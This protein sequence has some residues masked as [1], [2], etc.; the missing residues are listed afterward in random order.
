[1]VLACSVADLLAKMYLMKENGILT[2]ISNLLTIDLCMFSI[3]VGNGL[4]E[5][6]HLLCL[7]SVYC[8]LILDVIAFLKT[9][10]TFQPF[11]ITSIIEFFISFTFRTIAIILL[12]IVW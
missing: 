2:Y 6:A 5:I 7:V 9:E 4:V 10:D 11:G 8:N 12:F 1:M 3:L